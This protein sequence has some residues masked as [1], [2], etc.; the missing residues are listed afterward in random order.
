MTDT[1]IRPPSEADREPV[2]TAS[3]GR[4]VLD[5]LR[6]EHHGRS[7]EGGPREAQLLGHPAGV[8]PHRARESPV[9]KLK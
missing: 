6:A 3:P 8:L 7:G 5:G 9:R 4:V 2:E 1:A